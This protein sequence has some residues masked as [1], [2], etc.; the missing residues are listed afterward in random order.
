MIK[1]VGFNG[2]ICGCG[3]RFLVGVDG[4]KVATVAIQGMP[5]DEVSVAAWKCLL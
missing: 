5:S 2:L 3:F 1:K 4:I